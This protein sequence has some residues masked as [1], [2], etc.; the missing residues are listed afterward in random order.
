GERSRTLAVGVGYAI[1]DWYCVTPEKILAMSAARTMASLIIAVG[2]SSGVGGV[3]HE[4]AGGRRRL[5]RSV[6]RCHA[7][8]VLSRQL[9]SRLASCVTFGNLA[10]LAMIEDAAEDRASGLRTP[11]AFVASGAD[12]LALELVQTAHDLQDEL[13]VRRAGIEPR[14]I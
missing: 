12:Q 4:R 10:L 3:L 6:N 2:A 13:A 7:A 5:Q 8:T 11:D 9:G 14:I 1:P